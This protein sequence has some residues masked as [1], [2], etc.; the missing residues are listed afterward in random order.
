MPVEPFVSPALPSV[1][2]K[3]RPLTTI[4][5]DAQA[6]ACANT[7]CHG[8]GAAPTSAGGGEPGGEKAD[9]RAARF[10]RAARDGR[11]P[12][13]ALATKVFSLAEASACLPMLDGLAACADAGIQKQD[14]SANAIVAPI[15]R[16]SDFV[17]TSS[18]VGGQLRL[19]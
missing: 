10:T 5:S 13:L 9:A 14:H 19:S 8:A 4:G 2:P 3:V 1:S 12:C 17:M 15:R 6:P 11:V 16:G 7:S 18:R